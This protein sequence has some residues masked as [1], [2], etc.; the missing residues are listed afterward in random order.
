M[1]GYKR[2]INCTRTR[3]LA[4]ATT[5]RLVS[6]GASTRFVVECYL[7]DHDAFSGAFFLLGFPYLKKCAQMHGS[8]VELVTRTGFPY[9]T[10]FRNFGVYWYALFLGPNHPLRY[11]GILLV[12]SKTRGILVYRTPKKR[13]T[14][15]GIKWK[16]GQET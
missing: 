1:H 4:V 10:K 5:R 6:P 8:K 9:L 16:F 7:D 15:T 13:Y 3:M 2:P 12:F 11:I 14:C